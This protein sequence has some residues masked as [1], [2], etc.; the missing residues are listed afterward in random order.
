MVDQQQIA[1][2]IASRCVEKVITVDHV[3]PLWNTHFALAVFYCACLGV[4]LLIGTCGNV[5]IIIVTSTT[6][7]MNKV[8]KHFIINLAVSDLCVT[9]I[10]EPMCIVGKW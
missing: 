9:G 3:A 10:A 4:A 1:V 7:A 2:G 6:N 8:G 5:I